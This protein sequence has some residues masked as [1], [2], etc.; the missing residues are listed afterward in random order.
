MNELSNTNTTSAHETESVA[1]Y[2]KLADV[3]TVTDINNKH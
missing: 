3:F 1:S 2:S